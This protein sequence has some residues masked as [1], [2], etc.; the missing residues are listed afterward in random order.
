MV[1]LGAPGPAVWAGWEKRGRQISFWAQAHLW[2]EFHQNRSRAADSAPW[3]SR[4]ITL[5]HSTEASSMV[6]IGAPNQLKAKNDVAT[7]Y[8]VL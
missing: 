7:G 1:T 3:V 4:A 5:T 6:K 2:C 8:T